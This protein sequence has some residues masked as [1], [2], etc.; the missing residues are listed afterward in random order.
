MIVVVWRSWK[1]VEAVLETRLRLVPFAVA[2]D[3]GEM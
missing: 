2:L 3:A 1:V